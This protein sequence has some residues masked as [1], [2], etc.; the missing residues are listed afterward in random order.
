MILI[1]LLPP[2]LRKTRRQVDPVLAG[3]V[4]AMVVSLV[5]IGA[6]VWVKQVRLPNAIRVAEERQ[7]ELQRRTAEAEQVEQERGQIAEFEKHR[8]MIISLL[9]Q[10]V[11]WAHTLDEFINHLIS[12]N[13]Q[14]F[15][16]SCTD[17]QILPTS[18]NSAGPRAAKAGGN[19]KAFSFRG[20]YKLLGE[21]KSKAG[22]YINAFFS[23]TEASPFWKV[24]G[25]EDKPE[26]TYRGDQPEW[27][28]DIDR[29]A[30]DFTLEWVRVKNVVTA[31]AK[32]GR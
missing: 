30:V 1:N 4:A 29:V 6:M 11:F 24:Q 12:P 9:A 3:W 25:F 8:E 19:Q 15:E 26:R 28:K 21:D 13:W 31:S 7:E 18:T 14:G 2:E 20:R 17:L 23:R 10:K 22:D 27:R 32:A 16:V 5:P